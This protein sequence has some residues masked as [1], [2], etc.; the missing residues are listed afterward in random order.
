MKDYLL[1]KAK[2]RGTWNGLIGLATVAGIAVT[3]DQ[4]EV[5]ATLGVAIASFIS[6]F[7]KG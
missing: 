4:A 7:T 2:E 6:I 1:T 5:I 3:P